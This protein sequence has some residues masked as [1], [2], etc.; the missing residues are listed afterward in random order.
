MGMKWAATYCENAKFMLKID[1]DISFNVYRVM[2]YLDNLLLESS[3]NLRKTMICRFRSNSPTVR[4]PGSKF[5]VSEDMYSKDVYPFYCDGPAYLFTTD[6]AEMFYMRSLKTKMFVF[7]DVY[8]G[9]LAEDLNVKFID[10]KAYYDFYLITNTTSIFSE[11]AAKRIHDLFFIL[12]IDRYDL[13]F[14]WGSI[15]KKFDFLNIL[16]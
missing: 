9:M 8:I 14:L 16:K 13:I 3:N 11:R 7:E 15:T 4:N 5:F 12:V 2:N 6:L 1:D 10:I